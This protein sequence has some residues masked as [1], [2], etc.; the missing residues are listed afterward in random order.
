[1]AESTRR[2][3]TTV[4]RIPRDAY[5]EAQKLRKEMLKKP[6]DGSDAFAILAIAGISAFLGG[7]IGYA[8]A[9][10]QKSQCRQESKQEGGE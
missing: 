1:M 3:G 9:D 6:R 8:I 10:M 2:E 4:V 7:L 5:E